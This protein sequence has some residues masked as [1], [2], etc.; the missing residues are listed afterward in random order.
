MDDIIETL[1][2]ARS[3]INTKRF[4]CQR[5][6][7]VYTW[8]KDGFHCKRCLVGAIC[9]ASNNP[10]SHI[11]IL[12]DPLLTNTFKYVTNFISKKEEDEKKKVSDIQLLIRFNDNEETE[13]NNVR[14][15][16]D[17]AISNAKEL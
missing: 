17:I 12:R 9:K 1:K 7:E 16:L 11:N 4:W 5:N 13:Y 8:D 10:L 14:D 3:F 15:L 2:K 6:M